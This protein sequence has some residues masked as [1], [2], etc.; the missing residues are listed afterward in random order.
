MTATICGPI[1]A[2][3]GAS[4]S[5]TPSTP[6][7]DRNAGKVLSHTE[8]LTKVWGPEYRDDRDYLWAYIRHLRRKLEPDAEHP[9]YRSERGQG[10][11]AYRA[12]DQGVGPRIPR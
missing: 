10:A 11:V 9:T 8:L 12:A 1:S 5:P 6:R 7:T 4:S 3:C 2:T